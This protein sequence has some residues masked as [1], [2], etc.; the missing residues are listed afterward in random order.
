MIN[1]PSYGLSEGARSRSLFFEKLLHFHI[2]QQPCC[3]RAA[4]KRDSRLARIR[5]GPDVTISRKLAATE[6]YC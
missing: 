1:L 6:V 2:P 3:T 5:S 4:E